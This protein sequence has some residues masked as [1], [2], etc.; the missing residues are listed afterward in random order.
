MTKLR[1]APRPASA[2][3]GVYWLF[4]IRK[5]GR[6]NQEDIRS[7]CDETFPE[8]VH[9]FEGRKYFKFGKFFENPHKPFDYDGCG[10][11][12]QYFFFAAHFF[13]LS[14]IST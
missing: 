13:F 10:L 14:S 7:S 12:N 8:I 2:L 4:G 9:I 11:D 3:G 6:I 1:L 5:Y